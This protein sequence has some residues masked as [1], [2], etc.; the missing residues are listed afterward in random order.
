MVAIILGSGLSSLIDFVEIDRSIAY[1]TFV[2]FDIFPIAG[3]DRILCEARLCGEDIIILS[4]KL[5]LYEGYS[6]E[7]SIAPLMYVANNYEISQWIITSAS[8]GLTPK[9]RVGQWQKISSI[10]TLEQISGLSSSLTIIPT[11]HE[12]EIVYAYQKG[13]A[14]GTVAEYNMLAKCGADVV[15][16]SMLPESIYLSSISAN[17]MLYTLPVCSYDP[18]HYGISEPS[19]DEVVA[20]A[21][22]AVSDL[23][24]ILESIITST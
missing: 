4:G 7:K 11:S 23:V 1:D 18:I 16:M 5:H 24:A 19:H 10:V 14:L 22:E 15:G 3:H 2:D 9:V 17:V 13:P 21:K 6:Y 8:G 12:N 20:I